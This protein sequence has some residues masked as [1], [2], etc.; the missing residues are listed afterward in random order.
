VK[1][2]YDALAADAMRMGY[3]IPTKYKSAFDQ[4]IGYPVLA[5]ANLYDMYYAHAMNKSLA[6]KGDTEANRWADEVERCYKRDAE[7]TAYYHNLNGGKW[8][9]LMDQIHIGYKS[10][11]NPDSPSM[12]EV[13]RVEE[14]ASTA[15]TRPEYLFAD[16][17]GYISMEA[18]HYTRTG[19][20]SKAAWSVVPELGQ[21]LS[22]L[23][24][25]P[26]TASP[27]GLY[28]EY[29]FETDKTGEVKVTVRLA[30]TLNFNVTG[31][32]YAVSIDG[33]A[34]E[35]VNINGDY[36]G[37]LGKIQRE[38]LIYKRSRLQLGK[39]SKHT[40]RIRPLDAGLVIENILINTGNLQKTYLGAPETLKK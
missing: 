37:N 20:Q 14:K 35:T 36:D 39:G 21:N 40:L 38:H 22:G 34:E 10:W 15:P 9:H 2:D 12:P 19:G 13:K 4:L 1:S 33:G 26:A 18:E 17:G 29:D 27:E 31:L 3:S 7:L 32:R 11:N 16:N 24:T 23:T 6:A 25:L 8:N 28:A 5:C 30:P